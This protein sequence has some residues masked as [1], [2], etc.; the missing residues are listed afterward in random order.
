M[1]SDLVSYLVTGFR[2]TNLKSNDLPFHHSYLGFALL[3]IGLNIIS[4]C[5]KSKWLVGRTNLRSA[6]PLTK[7]TH[8]PLIFTADVSYG[9]LCYT[10]ILPYERSK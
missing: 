8:S 2:Q 10:P 6:D 3:K 9:V 4:V 1:K 7:Y 5:L